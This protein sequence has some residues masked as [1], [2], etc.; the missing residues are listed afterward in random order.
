MEWFIENKE[1][2]SSLITLILV[3]I[4]VVIRLTP[5]KK[6][7]AILDHLLEVK[8]LILRGSPPEVDEVWT[9]TRKDLEKEVEA[10]FYQKE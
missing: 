10:E 4:Y 3:T 2:L 1:F 6:D 8:K 5:T 7:D 9:Q